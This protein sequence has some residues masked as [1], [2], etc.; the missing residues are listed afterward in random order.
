MKKSDLILAGMMNNSDDTIVI[1]QEATDKQWERVKEFMIKEK[2]ISL[3][4]V[5]GLKYFVF[6]EDN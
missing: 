3:N 2:I 5:L 4:V 1:N 6:D